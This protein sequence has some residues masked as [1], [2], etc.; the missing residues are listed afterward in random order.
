VIHEGQIIAEDTP[1]MIRQSQD[2]FIQQFISG[3][4]EGPVRPL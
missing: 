3:S 4:L 1:E 2:P